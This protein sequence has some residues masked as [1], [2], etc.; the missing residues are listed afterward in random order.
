MI[1]MKFGGTSVGSAQRIN[2]VFEIVNERLDKKPIVVVSAVSGITD[3]ILAYAKG[4]GSFK[5]IQEKHYS[6][7]DSLGIERKLI[8]AELRQ[9]KILGKKSIKSE[10]PEILDSIV[11]LGERM[12]AKIVAACMNKKGMKAQAYNAYDVGF[13]TD[14]NFTDA[15]ILPKT[16]ANIAK[17]LKPEEGVVPVITGFIA[18]NVKGKITTLGRGG[19]DYTAAIIGAAIGADEIQIWTDVSGVKTTDPKIVKKAVTVPILSF[20]EASELAYFGAKILHPKT[21]LPAIDK[22]IPVRVL[23]TYE[24]THPGTLIVS[25]T[26]EKT[27]KIKAIAC[28]RNITVINIISSRML[29]AYGFM[30]EIFDVF[31]KHC[32]V[33]DLVATSEVS[34]SVT[35]SAKNLDALQEDLSAFSKVNIF[36]N[37]S[38]ISVVGEGLKSN[39]EVPARVFKVIRKA[40]ARIEMISQGASEINLSIV[41]GNDEAEK[42]VKMLHREFF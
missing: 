23:N 11:S 36:R 21:I 13:V 33:V 39:A 15:E 29:N 31:E 24:P 26:P 40:D 14:S 10:S 16:Y 7:I 37:K 8:F 38:I 32:I 25:E 6:I 22:E 17:K 28:K 42:I 19:S 35:V 34:V 2:S 18:K 1:V 20:K 27:K 41:V 9:L 4:E 5:E 3:M 30:E 12:S